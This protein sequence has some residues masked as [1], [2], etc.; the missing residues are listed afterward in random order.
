MFHV[1]HLEG[2]FHF[3]W[4][5]DISLLGRYRPEMKLLNHVSRETFG[6]RYAK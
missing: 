5:I 3:N 1:K 2:C 6:V 4:A